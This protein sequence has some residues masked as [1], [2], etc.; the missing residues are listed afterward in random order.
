M[1]VGST[2]IFWNSKSIFL[3]LRQP[4]EV[5]HLSSQYLKIQSIGS[6]AFALYSP[7]LF[8]LI[9][10]F[11]SLKRYMQCQGKM[12]VPKYVLLFGAQ[13]N[14]VMNYWF[15]WRTSLGFIGAPIA[16]VITHWT[17]ALSPMIYAAIYGN[18]EAWPG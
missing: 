13:M 10:R 8:L 14:A 5:I 3:L 12:Q 18:K 11:E 2:I 1:L 17:L 15:V 6:P 16:T 7:T 4:P 9:C